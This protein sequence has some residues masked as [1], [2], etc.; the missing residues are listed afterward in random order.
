LDRP[1][2]MISLDLKDTYDPVWD[3]MHKKELETRQSIALST[4]VREFI[5][6]PFVEKM[7]E[8]K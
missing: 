2:T 7:E 1:K 8:G 3:A 6:R 5:V 4:F